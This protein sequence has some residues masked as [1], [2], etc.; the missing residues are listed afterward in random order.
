MK[1]KVKRLPLFPLESIVFPNGL[2][3]LRIFETRYIDMVRH[4]MREQSSFVVT[5]NQRLEETQDILTPHLI[6]TRVDIIDFEQLPDG[7]LGIT[8][9]GKE[10]VDIANIQ[11]QADSLLTADISSSQLDSEENIPEDF[12]LLAKVLK[13]M[14]PEIQSHY[15]ESAQQYMSEN[16]QDA[17]WVSSRLVEVLPMDVQ[18]K[19]E[20]LRMQDSGERVRVIY[21]ALERMQVI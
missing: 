19:V 2:L 15:G 10:K 11:E 18:M 4:C 20:L 5:A 21:E 9:H 14:F 7:L 16:Y 13:K 6:G 8:I 3:A 1:K 12:A 17:S